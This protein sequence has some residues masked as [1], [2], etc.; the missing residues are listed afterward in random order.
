M[1]DVVEIELEPER[2]RGADD[3]IAV[4]GDELSVGKELEMP[5]IVRRLEAFSVVEGRKTDPLQRFELFCVLWSR[6][7]DHETAGEPPVVPHGRRR[8]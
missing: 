1:I 3:A 8:R 4:E 6:M 2:G 5:A 7:H